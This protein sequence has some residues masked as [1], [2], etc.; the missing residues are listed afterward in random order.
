MS[1]DNNAPSAIVRSSGGTPSERYLA[2]LCDRTFLNLWS[3]PNTFIDKRKGGK[4]DGKELCDLLVVCGDDIL[5]FSDK[6]IEWPQGDDIL[7]SWKRWYKRAIQSSVKQIRG[8]ERWIAE[9]PDRI[10][11]DRPCTQPFPFPLPPPERRKV[12]GIVVALGAGN[13]CKEYFGE[14]TGSLMIVPRI[15]GDDHF[16]GDHVIPFVIGDVD[17]T[18]AFV[19]VLD[20]ATLDIALRELDTITDFTSYLTKKVDFIRSGRLGA[21]A[22]EEEVIAYYLTHIDSLGEHGFT[23]P[24][25]ASFQEEQVLICDIGSYAN[26]TTDPAFI[27]KRTAD[28]DSYI[29]DNLIKVFTNHIIAGTSITPAGAPVIV[30]DV[31]QCVRHMALLPRFVRRMFGRAVLGALRKSRE[32]DRFTRSFL[33]GPG[34]RAPETAFFFLTL[35]VPEQHLKV[36][37]DQYRSVRRD[38]IQTYSLALLHR[39][40]TLRRVVGIATEPILRLGQAGSSEDIILVEDVVWTP[41]LIE[42]LERR[43][44]HYNVMNDAN[45]REHHL[46]EDEFPESSRERNPSRDLG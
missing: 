41:T 2:E 29:W 20:D 1:D 4:G 43:K 44:R 46:E 7:L 14:G 35:A 18:G 24:D 23:A 45:W 15:K 26:L 12:H 42:N 8:A 10:F 16:Q 37:Y 36:G 5:I 9:F 31:E 39:F 13:A 22:G 40:P 33:P 6:T 38:L 25:G 21:A 30:S 28:E 17:P 19:H 11:I 34:S 27:S 32:S 3:Y